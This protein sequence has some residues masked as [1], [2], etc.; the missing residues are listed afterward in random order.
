MQQTMSNI[1]FL[2]QLELFKDLPEDDLDRLCRMS[3]D[4]TLQPGEYLMREG[5]PGGSLYIILDG[6]FE[7]T[8]K[9]GGQE[10]VLAV[11]GQGE[12]IG[13]MSL[14]DKA[15]R[16]ASVRALKETRAIMISHDAVH[17]LLANS[18]SAAMAMFHTMTQRIRSNEAITRQSEKMA[19]LGT[20]AAGVAHELNNPA[21]AAQRSASQLRDALTRW[22]RLANQLTALQLNPEQTKLVNSLRDEIA[23]RSSANWN[24]DPIARSDRESELQDWLEVRGVDDAWELAPNLVSAGWDL[25]ALEPLD[26]ALSDEQLAVV[27]QWLEAGTTVYALLDEVAQSAARIS[28]I[29]KAVKSYSY[30]DQAPI[31]QV[32]VHEGLENTIVILKHKIKKGVT[33]KKEYDPALPRIE[34]LGSELNQAWTNIMDNALD[35]MKDQLEAGKPAELTIRTSHDDDKTVTVEMIDNGPGIPAEIR[36]RIFEPFFTTK[37]PG[38]GTGLG[39][40]ITYNIV[41]AKHH[42]QIAV[43]SKTETPSF[44]KFTVTLPIHYHKE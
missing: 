24:L 17:N 14:L 11:R 8:Q 22:L 31:Q 15:P 30:L 3:E 16:S 41:V 32:N 13:E 12:V 36:K 29:V 38:V 21:A 40:H 6:E 1:D 4:V 10:V 35:A 43:E 23:R 18:A 7:V 9:V 39:L 19:G 34:A 37:P 25:Q 28:E 26:K 33:I 20:L 2:R 42:G 5:D 27:V 44:T